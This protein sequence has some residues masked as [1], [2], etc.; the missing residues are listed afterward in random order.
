MKSKNKF[1]KYATN[2][3]AVSIIFYFFS[4]LLMIFTSVCALVLAIKGVLDYKKDPKI[5]GLPWC[6]VSIV[7][8]S[9][10]LIVSVIRII[11]MY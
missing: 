7:I 5:K 4:T 6:I 3:T 1:A 8:S 11:N 9:F 10:F 2:A